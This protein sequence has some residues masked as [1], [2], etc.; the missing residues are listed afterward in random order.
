MQG[1]H[2]TGWAALMSGPWHPPCS[3]CPAAA[4]AWDSCSL[5]ARHSTAQHSMAQHAVPTATCAR[6]SGHR[7]ALGMVC[8]VCDGRTAPDADT[9]VALG[10]ASHT[11][12][13]ACRVLP[14]VVRQVPCAW[15]HS[16]GMVLPAGTA[17][18]LRAGADLYHPGAHHN[19]APVPTVTL[20]QCP[21]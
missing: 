6:G 13:G 20:P 19:A 18:V 17:K 11:G 7:V 4:H 10:T 5:P 15:P 9:R 3:G 21:P 8:W 16:H 12:I 2:G 14:A 1:S